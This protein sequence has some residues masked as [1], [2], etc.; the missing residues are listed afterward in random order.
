LIQSSLTKED[1]DSLFKLLPPGTK[2]KEKAL[3]QLLRGDKIPVA[4][5]FSPLD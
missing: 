2:D 4:F 5:G 1:K 3:T